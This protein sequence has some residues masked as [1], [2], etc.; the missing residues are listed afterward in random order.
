[1]YFDT[2]TGS[3]DQGPGDRQGTIDALKAMLLG[4]PKHQHILKPVTG[5]ARVS[6]YTP[7]R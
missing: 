6:F 7:E 3:L 4:E 2:D 1:V 5:E